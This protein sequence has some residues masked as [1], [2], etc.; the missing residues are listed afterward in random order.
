MNK[1]V[2][3]PDILLLLLS[4]V[5]AIGLKTFLA[6]CGMHEDQAW[7]ACHWAGQCLWLLFCLL[8]MQSLVSL[9]W[10]NAGVRM[11]L[12]CAEAL[13]AIAC[14]LTPGTLFSLCM[15]G[16]MRC[17]QIMKPAALV[18]GILIS[19]LALLRLVLLC[20]TSRKE[21]RA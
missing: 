5:G 10:P 21:T 11:G 1:R 2:S 18:L 17:N 9:L 20:R 13:T 3:V 15:M 6:P 16:T 19:V 14:V 8:S 4:L 7:S 12:A